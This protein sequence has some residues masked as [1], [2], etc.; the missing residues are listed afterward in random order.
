MRYLFGVLLSVLAVVMFLGG[1]AALAGGSLVG[2]IIAWTIAFASF[3]YGQQQK[4]LE[5]ETF[6]SRIM[7]NEMKRAGMFDGSQ[8]PV[9]AKDEQIHYG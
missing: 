2:A 9:Q 7:V 6:R 4:R 8:A 3:L 1:I 5:R